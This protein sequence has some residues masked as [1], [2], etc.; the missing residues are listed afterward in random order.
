MISMM[1]VATV[2]NAGR[3]DRR[4]LEINNP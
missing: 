1:H 2:V 3:K 4:N